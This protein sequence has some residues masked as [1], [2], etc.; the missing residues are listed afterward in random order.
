MKIIKLS[1]ALFLV[2]IA[3]QAQNKNVLK[4]TETT[5]TTIKDSDGEK[6]LIK[7]EE[8]QEVQKIELKEAQANT[9]NVEIKDSPVEVLKTTQ[10]TN[11]DGS[12]RTVDVDRSGYYQGSNNVKYKVSLDSRGYTLVSDVSKKPALLRELTPCELNKNMSRLA[13][14]SASTIK[15]DH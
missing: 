10:I 13:S 2:S 9:I 11:A 3:T 6:K 8:T 15:N 4:T 14:V 5:T 12:T 7:K 1:L